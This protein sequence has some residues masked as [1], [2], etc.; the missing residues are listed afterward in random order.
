MTMRHV[1]VAG[2]CALAG[3][4]LVAC[5]AGQPTGTN[6]RPDA[7]AFVADANAQLLELGNALA[8]AQWVASNFITTDT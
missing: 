4:T 6:E 8:R 7:A 1:W 5:G 3:A 2:A